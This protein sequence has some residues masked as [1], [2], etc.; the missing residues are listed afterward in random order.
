MKQKILDNQFL[1]FIIGSLAISVI[2][3]GV[4]L[5]TYQEFGTVQLDLSRPSLQEAREQAK[6][7]AEKTKKEEVTPEFATE[8]EISDKVLKDFEKMYNE[9]TKRMEGDFF[10][11]NTLS[12]QT[13]NL[14]DEPQ[15]E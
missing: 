3:V 11:E 4:S 5:W 12:N 9:K 13:L 1:F 10:G 7:D 15:G 2:L 14:T 8:G 6:K